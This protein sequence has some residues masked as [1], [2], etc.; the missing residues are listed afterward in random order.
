M[1]SF[2]SNYKADVSRQVD[3]ITARRVGAEKERLNK[4]FEAAEAEREDVL[5]DLKA[6]AKV[7]TEAMRS[8]FAYE[9][10]SH[11]VHK[12]SVAV[13]AIEQALER[14]GEATEAVRRGARGVARSHAAATETRVGRQ[15][16]SAVLL[17]CACV[18][19]WF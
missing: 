2:Q 18:W 9:E 19:C 12:I 5:V 7:A 4:E 11:R 1:W 8:R 14:S 6:R 17:G 15:C 10:T 13:L 3:T 16:C